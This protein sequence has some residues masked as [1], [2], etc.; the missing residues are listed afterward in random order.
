MRG[1]IERI[2]HPHDARS[3][4]YRI[5]FQFLQHFGLAAPGEL[6]EYESLQGEAIEIAEENPEVPEQTL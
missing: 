4:K 3:Y 1:L 6:P 2:P 5:S